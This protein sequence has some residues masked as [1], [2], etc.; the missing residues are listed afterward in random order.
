MM[1]GLARIIEVV[2]FAPRYDPLPSSDTGRVALG[3][4]SSSEHTIAEG[5]P[6]TP[7]AYDDKPRRVA[8]SDA[9]RHLPPFV[10]I[11]FRSTLL[12]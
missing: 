9:F 3:D 2:Y 8:G 1:A 10:R 12:M 6:P 5:R 11:L 4:D 7:Q